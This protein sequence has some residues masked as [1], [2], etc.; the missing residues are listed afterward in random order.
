[1]IRRR[2]C[3]QA[4]PGIACSVFCITAAGCYLS[5]P[6][7][8]D[9][10]P[11]SIHEGRLRFS[12]VSAFRDVVTAL[13]AAP[14]GQLEANYFATRFPGFT[15]LGMVPLDERP[16]VPDMA[17]TMMAIM[18]HDASYE[19][20]DRIFM[21]LGDTEYVIPDSERNLAAELL[22]G[23]PP[24]PYVASER[25]VAHPLSPKA[26]DAENG[27]ASVTMQG[28]LNAKYQHEFNA[29]GTR[30]K[31]VDEVEVKNYTLHV[32]ACFR[33]KLE[34]KNGNSWKPAGERVYK[35]IDSIFANYV[36]TPGN[37]PASV[38][39]LSGSA[40]DSVNLMVCADVLPPQGYCASQLTLTATFYSEGN[41]NNIVGNSYLVDPAEW[42]TEFSIPAFNACD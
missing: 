21:V 9:S 17:T 3:Y 15:S 37:V 25:I 31:F 23:T 34:Y 29:G 1:M 38:G 36:V 22:S 12:S 24:D 33:S 42:L 18:N 26:S 14:A 7:T 10:D 30:F 5:E 4:I 16:D 11:V 35:T 40:N 39:P 19:V 32:T 27:S 13:N 20:A 41:H 8:N 28:A 2:L 6:A